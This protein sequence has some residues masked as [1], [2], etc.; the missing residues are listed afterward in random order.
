MLADS[1]MNDIPFQKEN[2]FCFDSESFRYLVALRNKITFTEED[3]DEYQKSW[4]T[5]VKESKRL[6]DYIQNK[7]RPY[8][9]QRNR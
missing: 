2:T 4:S 9:M 5:S 1:S 3:E 8:Y 7:L 6:I